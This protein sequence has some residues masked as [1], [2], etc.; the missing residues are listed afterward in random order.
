MKKR[1][2][3]I[4]LGLALTFTQTAAVY[5][6]ETQA[7]TAL[8]QQSFGGDGQTPP[9][10][11]NGEAPNGQG[12]PGGDG[13]TPPQMPNGEAPSGQ[14]GPG[15]DGQT[16]PQMPNGEAPDGQGGPGGP[17]GAPGMPGGSSQPESYTA[18]N[19]YTESTEITGE[20]IESTGTDENAVLVSGADAQVTV[21][22]STITR[23]SKDSTGGDSASFY[24]VGAA[25]LATDGTLIVSGSEITTDASGGAGAFAY[26]DGTVY[27]ADTKISTEQGA[28]GGIHVA[29]GGTLYAWDLDVTTQGGSAAAIRS[30]RG[31]GTMVVDGGSYTSNGIGSPAIYSTA[32]ITVNDADLTATSS[33]AICIEGLN[34]IRLFDCDLSGNM[35][36][37]DQNDITWNVIVY[38]S[39]SGDSQEGNGTFEMS[40]GTL[41]ANN[42]GMF[43]TTNT[44]STITLKDVDMIY[45]EDNP[46]FLQVTGNTNARGW[47]S[48]GNNGADCLFTAI[49]QEMEGNVVWDSISMLDFYM[50]DGSSLTGAIVNDETWAGDGGDGYCSLY[51]S[52]DSTWTVTGDS[53]LT[54]LHNAG[55]IVDAD[56]NTVTI[57]G[58]DG[59]VYVEGT[60]A[61]TITVSTYEE[62]ADTSGASAISNWEDYKVERL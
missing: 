58:T 54:S 56:G 31:S 59:T 62:T 55:T 28:S 37:D 20:T 39:M 19:E 48:A 22:D 32:D 35:G 12:G 33:E 24:G 4:V 9:E 23:T 30:D 14:G 57:V 53:T 61:Y 8:G 40:G 49:S 44:E 47:G 43:Y 16:P 26:G 29:G 18:L 25:M 50:I 42:G 41:T 3:A 60:S 11:P 45:S 5:A 52:D 27:I 2:L 21:T 36:D 38:Q 34:T 17:G 7:E 51:I 15:G 13:Q 10:L 46:F 1:Y 6:E